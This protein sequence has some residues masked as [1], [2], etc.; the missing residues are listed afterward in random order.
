MIDSNIVTNPDNLKYESV[1]IKTGLRIRL[2]VWA[3]CI[4]D[5]IK[6]VLKCIGEMFCNCA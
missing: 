1:Y 4:K 6:T 3:N 5:T 2:T